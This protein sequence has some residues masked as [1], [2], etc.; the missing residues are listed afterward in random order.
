LQ[1]QA[2]KQ[3][4]ADPGRARGLELLNQIAELLEATDG[5]LWIAVWFRSAAFLVFDLLFQPQ[6]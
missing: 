2:R 1:P 3:R 6:H 4:L 5:A